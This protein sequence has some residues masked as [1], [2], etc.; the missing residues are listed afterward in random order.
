[1][2][3]PFIIDTAKRP[4]PLHLSP[5]TTRLMLDGCCSLI[6]QRDGD[7]EC[8]RRARERLDG[9]SLRVGNDEDVRLAGDERQAGDQ[10]AWTG[11]CTSCKGK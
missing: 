11:R 1:M 9:L 2:Q 7:S 8:M 3:V 10:D 5:C 4:S 6:Y